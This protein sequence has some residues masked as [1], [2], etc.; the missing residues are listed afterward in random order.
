MSDVQGMTVGEL[1]KRL[2]T[3]PDDALVG[4]TYNYGDYWGTQ[5]W[6]PVEFAS[7]EHLEESSYS[8]YYTLADG[9]DWDESDI[10]AHNVVAI[11]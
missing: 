3:F 11:G 9:D 8:G 1:R 2:A 6:T 10:V 7:H 5:V 4:V